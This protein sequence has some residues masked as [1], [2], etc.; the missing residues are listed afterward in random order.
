MSRQE[1]AARED[2]HSRKMMKAGILSAFSGGI[3]LAIYLLQKIF[4]GIAPDANTNRLIDS[5]CL[6]L[7]GYAAAIFITYIIK[8]DWL[9]RVNAVMLYAV[10][11]G[12]M[13]K[14]FSQYL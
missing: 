6:T 14:L 8:R 10:I 2:R 3:G 11:P 5:V 9:L 12:I 1:L 7:M 13:L 4:S